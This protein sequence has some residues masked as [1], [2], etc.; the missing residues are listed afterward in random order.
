MA[1]LHFWMDVLDDGLS[2]AGNLLELFFG[3][4]ELPPVN[5]DPR[6]ATV[7]GSPFTNV[8]GSTDILDIL[9]QWSP[10]WV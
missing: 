6:P 10:V 5:G 7:A 3:E 9:S 2:V 8:G 1:I 4:V